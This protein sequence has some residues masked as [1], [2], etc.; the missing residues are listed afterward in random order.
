MRVLLRH[1]IDTEPTDDT[2]FNQQVVIA[3]HLLDYNDE[4]LEREERL[5]AFESMLE[6]TRQLIRDYPD[7]LATLWVLKRFP[8]G[9]LRYDLSRVRPAN[10]KLAEFLKATRSRSRRGL[11][12]DDYADLSQLV[13]VGVQDVSV[14]QAILLQ[15]GI[16]AQELGN[17]ADAERHYRDAIAID[18]ATRAGGLA[19]ERLE[20]LTV[21]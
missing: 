17:A 18:P 3:Q 20:A 11:L 5:A 10:Q 6:G 21:M 4:S 16:H 8:R 7:S 12:Q 2:V 19:Q 15:Q 9:P 14:R 1:L 13:S